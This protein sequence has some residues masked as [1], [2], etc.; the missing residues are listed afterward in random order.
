MKT[1]MQSATGWKW[2][3]Y[4]GHF[5]GGRSCAYHL[6]TRVG[7][8]LIS[9][10]GDYYS[11]KGKR[12]TLGADENSWFETFVFKCNGDDKN[13][14]PNIIDWSE[15][16]SEIYATSIEAERGHYRL[17]KKYAAKA[18]RKKKRECRMSS[19]WMEQ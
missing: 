10:V 16:D 1:V 13:G 4:S 11:Q 18:A 19:L 6:C 14:D 9:T 12:E 3:G 5:I 8:F 7:G 2:Y 17:C 15:I